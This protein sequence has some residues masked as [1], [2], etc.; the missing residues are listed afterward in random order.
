MMMG[1]HL[2]DDHCHWPW[3]VPNG[4]YGRIGGVWYA[5]TPNGLMANLDNHAITEHADGTITASPSILVTGG[6][7]EPD[8]TYHGFLEAGVWRDA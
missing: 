3:A 2:V 7:D 6:G 5:K 8:A 1:T 4:A